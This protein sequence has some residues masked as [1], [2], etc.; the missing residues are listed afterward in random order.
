MR[1]G[2]FYASRMASALQSGAI[3][4]KP[5]RDG[6]VEAAGKRPRGQANQR[7]CREVPADLRGRWFDQLLLMVAR[8]R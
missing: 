3:A 5:D 8:C 2:S 4:G 7:A 6:W 1:H